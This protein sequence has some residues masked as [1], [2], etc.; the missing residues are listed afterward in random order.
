MSTGS[1]SLVEPDGSTRTVSY[2]ADDHNGFNAV[3]HK[4]GHAVHPVSNVKL[5]H[6]IIFVCWPVTVVLLTVLS[7]TPRI[8]WLCDFVVVFR[9]CAVPSLVLVEK[10]QRQ[11]SPYNIFKITAKLTTETNSNKKQLSSKYRNSKD[12]QSKHVEMVARDKYNLI[13]ICTVFFSHIFEW[14][15][16]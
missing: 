7:K 6:Y 16:I 8:L 1:Y 9:H 14:L 10:L 5:F 2:A 15:N 3:V 4:T 13:D 12:S 11:K